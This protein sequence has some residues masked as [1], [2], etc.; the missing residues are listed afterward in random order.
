[1]NAT[2][3]K[4]GLVVRIRTYRKSPFDWGSRLKS[5]MGT[6]CTIEKIEQFHISMA[7]IETRIYIKPVFQKNDVLFD[8]TYFFQRELVKV[9]F[10]KT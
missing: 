3:I 5:Y 2:N 6:V 4:K 10:I 8:D 9:N 7:N 1:M